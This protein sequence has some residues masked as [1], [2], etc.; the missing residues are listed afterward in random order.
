[1]AVRPA[2]IAIVRFSEVRGD[3]LID[4]IKVRDPIR[5]PGVIA[6]LK[7]YQR[8]GDYGVNSAGNLQTFR[9]I[10]STGRREAPSTSGE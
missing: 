9:Q 7:D 1:M 3:H 6:H 8:P 2:T 4:Q 10:S 5:L